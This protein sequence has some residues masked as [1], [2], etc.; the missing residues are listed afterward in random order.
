MFN[1]NDV[2]FDFHKLGIKKEQ[3]L[4]EFK[5]KIC[6]NCDKQK[7]CNYKNCCISLSDIIKIIN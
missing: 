5:I 3:L 6:I 7:E 4:E 1:I 2:T